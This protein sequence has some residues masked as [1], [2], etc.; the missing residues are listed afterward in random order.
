[1][2]YFCETISGYDSVSELYCKHDEF[3]VADLAEYA[4]IAI[5]AQVVLWVLY[6]W[7][8]ITY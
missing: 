1:M 5:I 7:R 4:V 3:S 2:S 8:A 6:F